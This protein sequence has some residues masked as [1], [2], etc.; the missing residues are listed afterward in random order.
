MEKKKKKQAEKDSRQQ[1]A[2]GWIQENYLQFNRL[3]V[4][5]VRQRV[6]CEMHN[7]Q[8]AVRNYNHQTAAFPR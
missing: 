2:A 7:A 8:C 1:I 6:Q 3:R 5:T 4:D